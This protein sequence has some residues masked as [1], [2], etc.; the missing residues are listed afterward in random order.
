MAG[1]S[2]W[3]N[4]KHRK[5]RQDARRGKIFTKLIRAISVAARSGG[6]DIDSNSALR[7]AVDKALAQ[8]MPRDTI[9]RAIKRGAG[10]DEE[11]SVEEIY[12]E[13]YGPG[14]VA[15]L[16][17]CLTDNRNRTV[18]AIR[19]AFS[20]A[21]GHLGTDGSV[22]YLFEK[23]GFV[24]FAPESD[25]D[26]IMEIAL[27]QGADDVV[28]NADGSIDVLTSIDNFTLVRDA[29]ATEEVEAENAEIAMVPT[30]QVALDPDTAEKILRLT[31]MLDD[32]DD[33]QNVYHNADIPDEVLEKWQ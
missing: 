33:V 17:E 22:A 21:G 32:L 29:I 6:G 18:A 24:T 16:V 4:I 23:R 30:T 26:K 28:V 9:D 14:G 2:K 12:Y 27:E 20:K 8:N 7:L 11:V 10:G 19:H 5:G 3:A 1:H 13:G 15:F 31:D 25:E